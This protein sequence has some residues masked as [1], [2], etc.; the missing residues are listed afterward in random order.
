MV[1]A[2]SAVLRLGEIVGSGQQFALTSKSAVVTWF[3]FWAVEP[4]AVPVTRNVLPIMEACALPMLFSNTLP[5]KS[6]IFLICTDVALILS[7]VLTT[8]LAPDLSSPVMMVCIQPS[9]VH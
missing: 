5:V 2:Q 9:C 3:G 8:T 1:F 4:C 7:P 6:P